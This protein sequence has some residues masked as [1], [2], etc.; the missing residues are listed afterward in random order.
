MADLSVLLALM[1]GRNGG[2]ALAHVK[3]G[4]V[5]CLV[6]P[7]ERILNPAKPVC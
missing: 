1:A 3:E 7:E 4:E 2:M 5:E 6:L